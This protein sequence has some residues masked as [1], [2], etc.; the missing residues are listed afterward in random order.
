MVGPRFLAKRS[1]SAETYESVLPRRTTKRVRGDKLTRCSSTQFSTK[2]PPSLPTLNAG[3]TFGLSAVWQPFFL[4][5]PVSEHRTTLANAKSLSPA[6]KRLSKSSVV[7][8]ES[9]PTD[10]K[11]CKM[12]CRI[13]LKA[14][15][16][17]GPSRRARDCVLP[18]LI[19]STSVCGFEEPQW[20]ASRTSRKEPRS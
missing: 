17:N 6:S 20:P 16:S 13:P 11:T 8:L 18:L 1:E 2:P 4:S 12:R 15:A 14:T 10:W 19:P 7:S 5:I 9:K 3:I